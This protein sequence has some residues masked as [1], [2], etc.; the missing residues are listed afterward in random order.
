MHTSRLLSLSLLA[1]FAFRPCSAAGL[2]KYK[3]WASSPEAYFLSQEESARWSKV[4]SDEEAEKFVAVYKAARGKGFEAAIQS[5]IAYADAN[6]K[7]GKKRGSETL[8]GK[9]LIVLGPPT[10]VVNEGASSGK[11]KVDVTGGDVVAA[12]G[13]G[14]SGGNVGNVHSNAGGPGAD[15]LRGLQPA[16]R[17]VATE[18]VYEGSSLPPALGTK[19]LK[20]GFRVQPDDGKEEAVDAQ[21]LEKML[22]AVVESWKPKS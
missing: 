10:R 7:L 20:I 12:A 13:G 15:T 5:R 14:R 11:D 18:W 21:K 1:A 9:T 2:S 19:D 8:R 17:T 3:S 6:F 16:A 22:A 4:A